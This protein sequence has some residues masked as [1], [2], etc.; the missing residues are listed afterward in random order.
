MEPPHLRQWPQMPDCT[1]GQLVNWPHASYDVHD[2]KLC[3]HF[4]YVGTKEGLA[5][6]CLPLYPSLVSIG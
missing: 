4:F 5:E 1:N 3:S 2:L 6:S